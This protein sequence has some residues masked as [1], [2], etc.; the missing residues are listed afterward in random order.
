MIEE[1]RH[2]R[3]NPGQPARIAGLTHLTLLGVLG[4][5][6]ARVP[7]ASRPSGGCGGSQTQDVDEESADELGVASV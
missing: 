1:G 7:L 6:V 4:N 3:P 5:V 2:A